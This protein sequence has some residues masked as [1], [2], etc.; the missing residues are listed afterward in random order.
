MVN[1]FSVENE[2]LL[3]EESW[4]KKKAVFLKRNL[5]QVVRQRVVSWIDKKDEFLERLA[6]YEQPGN[7][8]H[9]G[10][11][12]EKRELIAELDAI[13][14]ENS[15]LLER[16]REMQ[17]ELIRR[18]TAARTL[19]A[20]A[21]DIKDSYLQCTSEENSLNAEIRFMEEEKLLFEDLTRKTS[22]TYHEKMAGLGQVIKDIRFVSGEIEMW[23]EKLLALEAEVP[24]QYRE[25][26]FLNDQI[27][28]SLKALANLGS[29]LK[30]V[31]YNV[32]TLYYKGK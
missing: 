20:M 17:N 3:A 10:L 13:E 15:S 11:S 9:E 16:Q 25:L 29:K 26:G 23:T 4:L 19:F 1:P 24:Q 32:K 30:Q 6:H 21:D 12:R 31:E 14:A 27:D 18:R 28:G 7:K 5:P 2:A 22:E 8:G